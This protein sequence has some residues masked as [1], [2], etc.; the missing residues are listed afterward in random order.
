MQLFTL[1]LG[2]VLTG[3]FTPRII[4]GA[5]TT[6]MGTV[7]GG[8]M[9]LAMGISI[10]KVVGGALNYNRDPDAA[11]SS[12]VQAGLAAGA[13]VIVLAIFKAFGMNFTVTTDISSF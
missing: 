8:I 9:V 13:C 3:S 5:I 6:G 11:K 7:V 10:V 2:R 12:F 4:A 1:P